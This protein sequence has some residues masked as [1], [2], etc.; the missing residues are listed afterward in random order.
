MKTDLKFETVTRVQNEEFKD[1]N[2]LLNQL[3]VRVDTVKADMSASSGKFTDTVKTVETKYTQQ[4]KLISELKQM[5]DTQNFFFDEVLP[6][7]INK[8]IHRLLI[9]FCR[10]QNQLQA[11][12]AVWQT[13][14]QPIGKQPP[15]LHEADLAEWEDE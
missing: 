12:Q 13:D 6:R 7:Q 14:C 8:S 9:P 2:Q 10:D 4:T 11:L 1:V 5:I 3:M 15:F